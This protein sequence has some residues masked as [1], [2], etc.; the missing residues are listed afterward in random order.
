MAGGGNYLGTQT[1]GSD[2][3]A[4]GSDGA[5]GGS[6]ASPSGSTAGGAS[7]GGA[8]SSTSTG[9]G[10]ATQAELD[11]ARNQWN[12]QQAAAYK[13]KLMGTSRSGVGMGFSGS[14][15]TTAFTGVQ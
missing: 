5:L 10:S 1:S 12:Q 2:S 11:Q 7:S 3:G 4:G 9:D 14:Q 15:A 8:A 6:A 13:Q